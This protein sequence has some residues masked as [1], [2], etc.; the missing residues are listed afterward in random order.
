MKQI[1]FI[2]VSLFAWVHLG[3]NAE[4]ANTKKDDRTL[5]LRQ[6]NLGACSRLQQSL[7]DQQKDEV[8]LMDATKILCNGGQSQS[9]YMLA[10]WGAKKK[11]LREQLRWLRKACDHPNDRG[12]A[13]LEISNL[14]E[15]DDPKSQ[16]LWR[17]KACE[18]GQAHVCKRAK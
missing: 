14:A 12:K 2:A 4:E 15:K 10:N 3:L 9:C 13:C 1:F 7:S 18:R 16:D 5:C 8:D 11:D 17:R 6:E